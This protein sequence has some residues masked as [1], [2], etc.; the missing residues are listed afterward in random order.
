MNQ[1]R[2]INIYSSGGESPDKRPLSE[3]V[4]KRLNSK[5]LEKLV[6][7]T[8]SLASQIDY[9][10]PIEGRPHDW[11]PP[12]DEG[13]QESEE[14]IPPDLSDDIIQMLKF[15]FGAP[16]TERHEYQRR[17]EEPGAEAGEDDSSPKV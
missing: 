17:E 9:F 16:V 5:Q 7:A 12:N 11:S 6:A 14:T 2:S 15:G 10:V 8:K 13:I 1:D 3:K 4:D